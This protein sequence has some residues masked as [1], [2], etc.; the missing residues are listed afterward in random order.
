MRPGP[1]RALRW[2]ASVLIRGPGS[3]FVLGDLDEAMQRDLERGVPLGQARARYLG[4][5]L[6]SA[7]S[8]AWARVW[9]RVG[10]LRVPGLSWVDV[11]LGWRVLWKHP[12]LSGVSVLSL[13]VGIPLGLVPGRV[14]DALEAPLPVDHG[15]R[16]VG[17]RYWNVER[18]GPAPATLYD[19]S[20]WRE[21]LTSFEDLGAARE[22]QV[23]LDTGS[24]GGGL[25]RGA[26]VTASTFAVLRARPLLGRM[27]DAGD[28]R[29]GSPPVV[30]LG[31]GI[32]RA[33]LRADPAAIGATVRIAG[34][35]HT[36][37]GVMPEGFRFPQHQQMWVPLP[38]AAVGP[39]ARG[40]DVLVFG[41][42]AD[43]ATLAAAR[44]ESEVVG[45]RLA[46]DHPDHYARMR[47]E[48][49]SFAAA[50]LGWPADGLRTVPVIR[51]IQGLALILLVVACV[52]VGLLVL[53]R[54]AT[55]SAELAVRTALGASRMRIVTQVFTEGLV[56]AV[57]AAG[58][59][60]VL[61]F[62][63]IGRL[64]D[65]VWTSGFPSIPYWVELGFSAKIV[66]QALILAGISAAAASVLPAL[67]ITRERTARDIR[68]A[69]GPGWSGV[70]FGRG[71]TAL[72]VAD[73]ALAVAVMGAS[74]GAGFR[75]STALSRQGVGSFPADEYLMVEVGLPENGL[76]TTER[77]TPGALTVR[78]RSLEERLVARLQAEPGVRGVAIASAL[79]GM[80]HSRRYVEVDGRRDAIDRASV[81]PGFFRAFDRP[82]VVGRAFGPGDLEGDRQVVIVNRA[83]QKEVMGGRNPLG[84]TLRYPS[85]GESSPSYEIV[86][87]AP[88]LGADPLNPSGG[89]AVYHV[90]GAGE[91]GALLMAIHLGPDPTSF[92]PRV[93]ALVAET[94][95]AAI[96][97]GPVRLDRVSVEAA[98]VLVAATTGLALLAGILLALAASGVYAIMSHTVTRRTR[99]IGIRAA[100]GARPVRIAVT[101]GRRA[102]LQLVAGA[103]LGAPL[104]GWLYF[105]VQD[106]PGTARAAIA[107]AAL[108]PGL[109]VTL[110]VG[111]AA[112]T[113]PLLRVLRCT[114][115]E[116]IRGG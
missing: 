2:L 69:G 25:V 87:V 83:F 64:L 5:T 48:V 53:A 40:P 1:G 93:R 51:L 52:N 43:G 109:A 39:E 41:R 33:R 38:D 97:G 71:A 35:P 19:L 81:R 16:V 104:A 114:P 116:A 100:L 106:D 57:V 68:R 12:V 22:V 21:A 17:L 59:G 77:D 9:R 72:V 30:V 26:H 4:N 79:P 58:L 27:L 42:L 70:R 101:I 62:G 23:N 44:E 92:A 47:G 55:R 103:L 98:G 105:L 29:P 56:L 110:L 102:A 73:V 60:V 6:A 108:G 34:V 24:G 28:E 80:D 75:S 90:V 78:R 88:D 63:L 74:I 94:D 45:R 11:K 85:D 111:M 84:H 14:I 36:V 8:L 15:E 95:P 86:G 18:S 66:V 91:L 115:T 65:A 46:A 32:W 61:V 112:C 89:A 54:A 67:R 96:V 113:A 107:T 50:A 7:S 20:V 10:T 3:R 82:V 99:E 76:F 13:A 37:V 49:V 31:Y